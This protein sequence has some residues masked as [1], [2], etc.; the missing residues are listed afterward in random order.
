MNKNFITTCLLVT[1]LLPSMIIAQTAVEP[2]AYLYEEQEVNGQKIV[3]LN[4]YTLSEK[5]QKDEERIGQIISEI[6]KYIPQGQQQNVDPRAVAEWQYY[7][8]QLKLWEKYVQQQV[9]GGQALSKSVQDLQFADPDSLDNQLQEIYTA[10]QEQARALIE[11][12]ST[13]ITALL[14]RIEDRIWQRESYRDWVSRN[15]EKLQEFANEWLRRYT[16]EEIEMEGK[17]YLI[18]PQPLKHIPPDRINIVTSNLTPYD[19]LNED[20]TLK[21]VPTAEKKTT[22]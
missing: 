13:E 14:S 1:V 15:R 9:L 12:Y 8:E 10:Y 16:G 2:Y 18:S 7:W 22:E 11:K 5:K 17:V 20:G 3:V 19:L 21:N 4:R 6:G